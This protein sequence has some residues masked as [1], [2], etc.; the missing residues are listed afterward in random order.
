MT[1]YAN[2]RL[3]SQFFRA[4]VAMLSSSKVTYPNL[5][6]NTGHELDVRN[7]EVN[8]SVP[9]ISM[10]YAGT[11]MFTAHSS[12]RLPMIEGFVQLTIL[13]K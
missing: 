11:Y 8:L 9:A 12:L 2:R 1:W 3:D 5:S 7:N 6:Y 13:G 4:A 10:D